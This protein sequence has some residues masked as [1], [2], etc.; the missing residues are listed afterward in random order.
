M[1]GRVLTRTVIGGFTGCGGGA[2]DGGDSYRGCCDRLRASWEPA[3]FISAISPAHP[4][5]H[6]FEAGNR[7]F[8]DAHSLAVGCLVLEEWGFGGGGLSFVSRGCGFWTGYLRSLHRGWLLCLYL[9]VL[10]EDYDALGAD[11][12]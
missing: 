9:P 10:H 1:N 12:L 8:Q 5:A 11:C 6:S 3:G 7:N 2:G 4:P